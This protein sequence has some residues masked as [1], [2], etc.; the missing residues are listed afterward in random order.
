MT[1]CSQNRQ[2]ML[3]LLRAGFS[4]QVFRAAIEIP[5]SS[6]AYRFLS[7]SRLPRGAQVDNPH[8]VSSVPHACQEYEVLKE[9]LVSSDFPY[10][11]GSAK[12]TASTIPDT[13]CGKINRS[14][15][16]PFISHEGIGS[17][18]RQHSKIL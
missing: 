13:E 10:T 7:S 5:R 1:L 9:E 2:T 18:F 6:L 14:V 3:L 8:S 11:K 4:N 16:A 15:V 17:S 12:K